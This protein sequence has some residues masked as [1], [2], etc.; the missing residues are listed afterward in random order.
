MSYR[1]QEPGTAVVCCTLTE[2]G[3]T[4]LRVLLRWVPN[5]NEWCRDGD[6]ENEFLYGDDGDTFTEITR[7]QARDLLPTV[8]PLDMEK[9][10]SVRMMNRFRMCWPEDRRTNDQLGINDVEPNVHQ[11]ENK[12]RFVVEDGKTFLIQNGLKEEL[13]SL[14]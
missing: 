4:F 1:D 9:A 3:E 6:T 5:L 13:Q 8:K 7:E 10:A 14:F 2:P 12:S 11:D